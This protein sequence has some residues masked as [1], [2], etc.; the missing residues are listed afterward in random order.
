M[1]VIARL[2]YELAYNDSAVHRFNHYT[3]RTPPPLIFEFLSLE[4]QNVKRKNNPILYTLKKNIP[5]KGINEIYIGLFEWSIVQE[6]M[7]EIIEN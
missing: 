3:T 7:T 2:E 6:G 4:D 1:N 5:N